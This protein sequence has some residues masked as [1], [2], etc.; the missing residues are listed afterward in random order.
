M[1]IYLEA[2]GSDAMGSEGFLFGG[3]SQRSAILRTFES[4]LSNDEF[5]KASVVGKLGT[6]S[7]RKVLVLLLSGLVYE[8]IMLLDGVAGVPKS[9][10][11]RYT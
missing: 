5:L 4:L 10:W 2:Y 9:R 6:H 8:G 7:I 3:A 11:W 1:G